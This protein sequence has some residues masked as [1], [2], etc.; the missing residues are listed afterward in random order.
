M[1][2][3]VSPSCFIKRS[4]D[5]PID[6]GS[7]LPIPPA[8]SEPEPVSGDDAFAA[9]VDSAVRKQSI[10]TQQDSRPPR[11]LFARISVFLIMFIWVLGGLFKVKDISAFVDIVQTH[12]V[13]PERYQSLLWWVGPGE[14][15]MGLLLVFV[16]G[17]ELRK[18]FGKF[19]L[20]LSMLAIGGFTYY[21]T[22]VD[23][24]V[25]Q[26]SGCGCLSEYRIASGMEDSVRVI[27]IGKNLILLILHVVA[28]LG[29][30]MVDSRR[31]HH[32]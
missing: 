13:I 26:E 7:G 17:S 16:M 22:L 1:T 4:S 3:I 11:Y 5:T 31:R 12:Q 29:P 6:S 30:A 24:V 18:P 15:V 25:L 27:A 32:A 9:G 20:V 2:R 21:L 23:P 19:V 14:L 8:G 28:L 10:E